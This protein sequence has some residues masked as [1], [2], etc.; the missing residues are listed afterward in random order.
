[1]LTNSH[2]HFRLRSAAERAYLE[3]LV[4]EDFAACHPGETLEDAKR[5]APFSRDDQGLLREWMEVAAA[6]AAAKK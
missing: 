3:S 1:M 2:D 6:R 4:R 5:R